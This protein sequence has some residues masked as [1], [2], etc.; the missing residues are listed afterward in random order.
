MW[1]N[2][3]RARSCCRRLNGIRPWEADGWPS[4]V[5]NDLQWQ[6]LTHFWQ[7][8]WLRQ[9]FL[10]QPLQ[11]FCFSSP[12]PRHWKCH[13]CITV[14]FHR[15]SKS[16][17]DSSAHIWERELNVMDSPGRAASQNDLQ[18]WFY[19][20]LFQHDTTYK[21]GIK[22]CWETHIRFVHSHTLK[23]WALFYHKQVSNWRF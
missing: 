7:H 9:H 8:F 21:T 10:V 5:V 15:W 18:S 12:W 16:Y 11:I 22:W 13:S 3:C 23:C 17:M 20:Q 2:V 14:H 1:S 19:S 6:H 4:T